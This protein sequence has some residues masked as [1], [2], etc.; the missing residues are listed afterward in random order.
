MN[1]ATQTINLALGRIFG[2]MQRP[3]QSGDVAE[4]ERCRPLIL[5]LIDPDNSISIAARATAHDYGRDRLRG[6]QGD[7]N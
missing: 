6:A 3:E 7:A 4:Y 2:M 5:R 1:T